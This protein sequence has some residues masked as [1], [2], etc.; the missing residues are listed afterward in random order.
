MKKGKKY[1]ESLKLIDKT[2]LYDLKEACE[3]AVKTSTAKF[4]ETV[5]LHVKL[6]VDRSRSEE[7]RVGKECRSRWS[8]YH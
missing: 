1:L 5:E 4:D 2:N 6:G 3:L 8:P 7:R